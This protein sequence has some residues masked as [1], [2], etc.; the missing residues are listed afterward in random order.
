MS[1]HK[2]DH[3]CQRW[4]SPAPMLA[5]LVVVT[6]GWACP[7]WRLAAASPEQIPTAPLPTAANA[8]SDGGLTLDQAIGVCLAN[9]P[10]L[11]AGM[12][13]VRQAR[14]DAWTAGLAPN[15]EVSVG[16]SLLPLGRPYTPD[17]PGGPPELDVGV[18]YKVDWFLFGK[19]AAALASA[20]MGICVSEAEYA[21]LVRQ[22]VAQVATAYYDVLAAQALLAL[23]HDDL[24]NLERVEG[25]TRKAVEN[26]GRPQ[27][28]LSRVQLELLNT[29]RA[30]RDSESALVS[31]KATLQT[32]LGGDGS[33]ALPNVSGT[34]DGPLTAQP[35]PAEAAF[36]VA[37][38]NRPDILALRRKV[39]KAQRDCVVEYRNALPE[40]TPE[41]GYARQYQTSIGSPDVSAWGTGITATIPLFNRNQGNR[42]KAASV[43]NQS[44]Y[45]LQTGLLELRAEI[46][47]A[48][49]ALRTAQQNAASVAQDELRLAAH[50]RDSIAKAYEIGGRPLIEVLDAQRNYRETY[51]IFV[52]ARADY[53][54]SL[55]KYNSA[56]GQQLAQ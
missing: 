38:E 3:S 21:D 15:P 52:T 1:Y 5:F 56:L 25:V 40:I 51:R 41:F 35:L 24:T 48:V 2:R 50:V 23:A 32:F 54:R 19:R 20:T 33:A 55:Y 4:T 17:R 43:V 8:A 42:S 30:Q 12:E 16:A 36:A 13:A 53:W 28:E 37:S 26:G 7:A 6:G 27:V 14:A 18:S 47:Q 29:R 45:E 49:Q 46:E 44:N 31:A 22:R 10:K 39:A 34:L 9:D 11:S